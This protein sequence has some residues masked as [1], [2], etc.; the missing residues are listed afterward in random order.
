MTRLAV[1]RRR[2]CAENLDRIAGSR[3]GGEVARARTILGG[4]FLMA[5]QAGAEPRVLVNHLGYE[6]DGPKRAVVQGARGDQVS[7]C[8]LV[9][10]ESGERTPLGAPRVVGPVARWRDWTYW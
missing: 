3:P 6:A 4:V 7:A 9:N 2:A 5:A 8:A 1:D 10:A